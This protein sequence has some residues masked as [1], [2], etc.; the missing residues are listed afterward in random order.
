[1]NI[2]KLEFNPVIN[3]KELVAKSVCES[4]EKWNGKVPKDSFCVATI[5]PQYAG[6]VELCN[7]YDIPIEIGANCLIVEAKRSQQVWYAACL[8]P[9]GYRYNM[10][11][12]VRK[13]LNARTVSVA[14]LDFVIEKTGMEYGSI[15]PIGL[16]EEWKIF[17]DPLVMKNERIIIGGGLVD[18]KLSILSTAFLEM[19]NVVILDGVA[20]PIE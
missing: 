3:N 12:V 16:P 14:P 13:A 17:V 9:V 15:T 1:M 2:G 5:D 11:S 10:T 6:G 20:K 18:S 7:Y 8:V 4:I 19:P